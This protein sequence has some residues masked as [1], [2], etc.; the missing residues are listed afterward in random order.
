MEKKVKNYNEFINLEFNLTLH[1]EFT[2]NNGIIDVDLDDMMDELEND[3]FFT[4]KAT[5][6]LENELLNI[7]I[8]GEFRTENNDTSYLVEMLESQKEDGEDVGLIWVGATTLASYYSDNVD[9]IDDIYSLLQ[10]RKTKDTILKLANAELSK[11]RKLRNIISIKNS[12]EFVVD[13]HDFTV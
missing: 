2:T 8:G 7:N 10:S 13:D 5:A 12:V 4:T 11:N 9:A 1:V 6:Y 3:E